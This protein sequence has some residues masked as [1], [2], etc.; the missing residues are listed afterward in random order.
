MAECGEEERQSGGKKSAK[1]L[2]KYET[3]ED[4]K[5]SSATFIETY[6]EFQQI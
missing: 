2:W 6:T 4:A 3:A 5:S 1:A